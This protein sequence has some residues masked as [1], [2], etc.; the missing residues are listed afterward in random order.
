MVLKLKFVVNI[1]HAIVIDVFLGKKVA[2]NLKS[3]G[4]K[5]PF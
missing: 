2:G 5:S 4:K 1:V 3:T